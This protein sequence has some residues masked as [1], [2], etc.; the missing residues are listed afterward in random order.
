MN[1]ASG[2]HAD[3]RHSVPPRS[4]RPR[5]ARRGKEDPA[6]VSQLIWHQPCS[7]SDGAFPAAHALE[8]HERR[9]DSSSD[10]AIAL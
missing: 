10:R 8:G 2:M 3:Q 6:V 7:V 9:F 4:L 5:S 1:A